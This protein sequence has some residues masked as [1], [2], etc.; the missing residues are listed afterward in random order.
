M[1]KLLN[2]FFLFGHHLGC[3]MLNTMTHEFPSQILSFDST[4][5]QYRI[6]HIYIS[7]QQV[8]TCFD[9][10]VTYLSNDSDDD[11]HRSKYFVIIYKCTQYD[12]YYSCAVWRRPSIFDR[13]VNIH[14]P[15]ECSI[16]KGRRDDVVTQIR[17]LCQ[18]GKYTAEIRVGIK[19]V[20]K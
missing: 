3:K 2:Y 20:T 18:Y 6:T 11:Q 17:I 12:I 13:D 1:S 19:T 5:E 16:A 9:H 8:L 7:L 4:Q 14:Y 10:H 15:L